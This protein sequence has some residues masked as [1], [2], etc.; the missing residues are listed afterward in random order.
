MPKS[1][2]I[3]CQGGGSHTVFTAG[4]L[5]AV[6][7]E[8]IDDDEFEI[9]ALSGTSGGA[10]CALLAWYGLLRDGRETPGGIIDGKRDAIRLLNDFWTK[11]WPEGNSANSYSEAVRKFVEAVQSM[12]PWEA[13]VPLADRARN[14]FLQWAGRW[15]ASPAVAVHPEVS[16]Y[17]LTALL[18]V[19]GLA[20]MPGFD[21]LKREIDVQEALRSLLDAYVDFDEIEEIATRDGYRPA[22][23]IGAA[24]VLAGEFKLFTSDADPYLWRTDGITMDAVIASAAIPT[25]MR[26][27]RLGGRVFWDGLFSQNPPVHDLPGMHLDRDPRKSPDEIWIIR[28]NPVRIGEEPRNIADIQDRRNELAGNVSLGVELRMIRRMNELVDSGVI[29]DPRYKRIEIREIEISEPIAQ[30][31]DYLSKMDR[32]PSLLG[33]LMEDGKRQGA[34]FL[35]DW[36]AGRVP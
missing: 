3:A 6:L 4:V 2:A 33:M 7:G 31:L 28:I 5:Q 26:G 23:L 25:V 34:A 13:A 10:I 11:G 36:G 12:Q 15:M 20:W 16:P 24:D 9:V 22:L 18:D 14:D 21:V 30:E 1:I 32:K 17:F 8:N 19:P 27:V 29:R 35:R